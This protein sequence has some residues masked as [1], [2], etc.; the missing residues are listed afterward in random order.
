MREVGTV[1]N[2]EDRRVTVR[3]RAGPQCG[4]CCACAALGGG[5]REL[6]L[7]VADP[8]AVGSHVVVEVST[9]NATVGALLIFVLPLLGLVGGVLAGHH[10]QPFGL[11]G[12]AD[13][14]VLGFGLLVLLFAGAAALDRLV[15]RARL[16]EPQIVRVLDQPQS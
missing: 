3:M 16:P 4:S 7:T 2:V 9:P 14:L 5:E 8:P 1:V 6:E 15:L 13:G 11:S 12:D 10:L